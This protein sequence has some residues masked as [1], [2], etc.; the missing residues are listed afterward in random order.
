MLRI[1]EHER[2]LAAAEELQ[3]RLAERLI[4]RL[5][6][7]GENALHLP[8]HIG[9]DAGQLTLGLEDIVPLAGKEGVARVHAREFVD[10]TEVRRTQRTDAAAQ[11]GDAAAG[12]GHVLDRL[13]QRLGRR[14]AE[15]VIVPELVEDLLFLHVG[16]ELFLLKA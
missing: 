7:R 13:A 9:D 16:R 2:R 15:L 8:R 5:K 6:L 10:R 12:L 11:F 3:K 4:D 14:A 1:L